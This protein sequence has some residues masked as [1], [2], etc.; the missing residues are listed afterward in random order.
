MIRSHMPERFTGA[1]NRYFREGVHPGGFMMA[2]LRNDLKE[3]FGAADDDA[4]RELPGVVSWLY[5]YAP[6]GHW[7]SVEAVRWHMESIIKLRNN[8][9]QGTYSAEAKS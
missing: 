4:V 2:V 8:G 6:M 7:G 5:N 1:L 9:V 3:A